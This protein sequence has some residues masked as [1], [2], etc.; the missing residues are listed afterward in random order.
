VTILLACELEAESDIVAVRQRARGIAEQLGFQRQDQTRIATAVSEIARNAFAYGGG[1]RVEFSIEP[2]PGELLVRIL[3]KGPGIADLDAV[4]DGSYHSPTGMGL[5]L[6]GARRLMDRFAVESHADHGTMVV[7][8][9]RLP[10]P[11]ALPER[12]A[13][14]AATLRRAEAADAHAALHE[15]NLE[16]LTALTELHERQEDFSRVNH[17]LEDTNRGVVALYAE[18]D[19]RA[20]QL[21]AAS[22]LKSRFLSN[23]SHEFRT[24]LNSILA[25]S[26]LLLDRIDG[27]LSVEQE[28]QVTFIRK[29]AEGLLELVNDLLD[30]AKVEAGKADV[31]PN[32]FSVAELF[33]ALRG[34][35]RPLQTSDAVQLVFEEAAH[36]P[37]LL[38]DEG[39]VSQILRNL[40][41]NSLKFTE[42]GE[43]RVSARAEAGRV[44]FTVRD[45][46]I[47]IPPEH[48]EAIFQE[49][50]QVENPLQRR[51]KGTGLGLSL[52]RKLAELLGGRIELESRV[53]QGSTFSLVLP[54]VY[55]SSAVPD[56]ARRP[57]RVLIVDDDAGF[58]YALRH[59]ISGNRSCEVT[60]AADGAEALRRLQ[61]ERPDLIFLDLK[62]PVAGGLEVMR[63]LERDERLRDVP[64]VI[65]TSLEVAAEDGGP[66]AGAAA[67]LRKDS[68]SS[69][70]V[71]RVL[72]AVMGREGDG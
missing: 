10:D 53:G 41:S 13:G 34:A 14:M 46:G 21:R 28:K 17:E 8:G 49:F 50:G 52:S 20:N 31:K 2:E 23:M 57:A 37:A 4:L 7:L 3:D 56:G 72:E 62:M 9:K 38:T 69:Q 30:I 12:L 36:L 29:S 33:G 27:E 19:E 63:E 16:L 66:L 26:R 54:P 11:A 60:E 39:K 59:F 45:T 18:L 5:G 58:R 51:A 70:T 64:V 68:L 48:H 55:G 44:V 35:L 42:A 71:G 40:I 67:V 1:G 15:Q 6:I 32:P 65:A 43:V 61:E 22:E 47:G 24:P 25:L